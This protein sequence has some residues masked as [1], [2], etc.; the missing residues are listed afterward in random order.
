[1][2]ST[3]VE[4]REEGGDEEEG[5][6]A[7]EEEAP[8][9]PSRRSLEG[10]ELGEPS[11]SKVGQEDSSRSM[12]LRA[13][14][15]HMNANHGGNHKT[16]ISNSE[17]TTSMSEFKEDNND[18]WYASNYEDSTSLQSSFRRKD[19]QIA[20]ERDN[21]SKKPWWRLFSQGPRRRRR[22]R[23]EPS[24]MFRIA[25]AQ[26]LITI[27]LH[28]LWV[29]TAAC[30]A[31]AL[32]WTALAIGLVGMN[33]PLVFAIPLAYPLSM[34]VAV[35]AFRAFALDHERVVHWLSL[36]H[37]ILVLVLPTT[38]SWAIGGTCKSGNVILWGS[39]SPVSALLVHKDPARPKIF[40][41]AF[42]A[43]VGFTT[44][45]EI[46][47]VNFV[48]DTS[49]TD[50]RWSAISHVL[51]FFTN[52]GVTVVV[53]G[54][55]AIKTVGQQKL[56]KANMSIL[57][58]IMPKA[59]VD[60]LINSSML[61]TELKSREK[62]VATKH[63][64]KVQPDKSAFI[65]HGLSSRS[66]QKLR[67][68]TAE[69]NNLVVTEDPNYEPINGVRP[70]EHSLSTIIFMDLVGFSRET[71]GMPPPAV[72]KITD[73]IFVA[74][75]QVART[76]KITKLRTIGDCWL[77]AVGLG[78]AFGDSSDSEQ[79]A[80]RALKFGLE[81]LEAVKNK[82]W[83]SDSNAK[84]QMRVGINSGGCF[85]GVVGFMQPQ[86][87]LYGAAV[88]LAA[89]FEQAAQPG[90]VLCSDQTRMMAVM[91]G[92]ELDFESIGNINVKNMGMVEAFIAKRAI[93][94]KNNNTAQ[95]HV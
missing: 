46:L 68:G 33:N 11:S 91:E 37:E 7:V 44:I 45:A 89:R 71:I 34:L 36:A 82:M 75:E 87:D 15:S 43:A 53:I 58:S 42:V 25:G 18:D 54:A 12:A 93:A 57:R 92:A 16:S 50:L 94:P 49:R 80:T 77:G 56:L 21:Q 26:K 27:S 72:L 60:E 90:T 8:E 64:R 55:L 95:N 66:L 65:A 76:H 74:I 3:V 24:I 9:A 30:S 38:L 78:E 1:M 86:Y 47:E 62:A 84:V 17:T 69:A 14:G 85:S 88:N 40:F 29:I 63:T 52:I 48:Y 32:L 39:I 23:R 35:A 20:N 67:G 6:D 4:V 51:N 5:G 2:L 19:S 28:S 31:C 10:G 13:P 70:R 59:V 83:H 79:Q 41:A 22:R 81:C 73:A 61:S